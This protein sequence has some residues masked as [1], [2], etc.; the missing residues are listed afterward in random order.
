MKIKVFY[1][2]LLF[3]I[4]ACSG[5]EKI[6]TINRGILPQP[7]PSPYN[8]NLD[9]GSKISI[10]EFGH[11]NRLE[12]WYHNGHLEDQNGEKWGFHFVIFKSENS[13]K[14]NYVAQMSISDIKTGEVFQLARADKGLNNLYTD[15]LGTL[16]ISD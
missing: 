10:H 15:N 16:F 7:T 9:L 4:S 2:L 3:I 14:D 5:E 11:D 8:L 12:W 13:D 6:S 1:I